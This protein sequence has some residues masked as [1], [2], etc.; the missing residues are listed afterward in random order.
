VPDRA[1]QRAGAVQKEQSMSSYAWSERIRSL[2]DVANIHIHV[3]GIVGL[4]TGGLTPSRIPGHFTQETDV[5]QGIAVYLVTGSPSQFPELN[6]KK[7]R[8]PFGRIAAI[9]VP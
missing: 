8:I 5:S 4:P 7:I 9:E 2:I 3:D 6:D 1:H